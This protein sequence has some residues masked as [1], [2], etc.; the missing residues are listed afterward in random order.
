MSRIHEAL[1]RAEQERAAALQGR[2]EAAPTESAEA[3]VLSTIATEMPANRVEPPMTARVAVSA[4]GQPAPTFSSTLNWEAV[5]TRS[6]QA[7]WKPDS[8]TMLFFG[9]DEGTRGTEQ[10]RTLRSR[11]YH[12]REKLPLKKVLVTSAL[13]KEGKSFVAANLAQVLARQEGRRVLLIDGDLR[14]PR[15]QSALGTTSTPGLGDYLLGE[16]DEVSVM[17]RGQMEGLFF[18]PCGRTVEHP[19]ELIAN[20][21]LKVLLQRLEPLFDW[22]VLDSPPAVPVSDACQLAGYC[23]GVLL[24]VRSNATPYDSAQRARREFQ[25]KTIVGVVLNGISKNGSYAHYYYD[26]YERPPQTKA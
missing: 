4:S 22:I 26:L 25:G 10:F 5:L 3:D 9:E 14:A 24:V 21:R 13:P 1:K 17:Q 2:R 19:A 20:G 16:T 23:D 18:M 11:L 8:K 6:T 7:H 12:M 15:L